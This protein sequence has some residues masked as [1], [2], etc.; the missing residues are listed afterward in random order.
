MIQP[1]SYD[2][3]LKIY[4]KATPIRTESFGKN[5]TIASYD[6]LEPRFALAY[7]FSDNKSVKLVTT[8]WFN[9]YN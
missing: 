9:T 3:E 1:V 4:E 7:E 2:S 8:A 5:K 6:N